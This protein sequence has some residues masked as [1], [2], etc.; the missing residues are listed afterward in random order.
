MAHEIIALIAHYGLLLVFINVLV[1][2]A[3]VPVPAVPTLVVAGALA[4]NG[5]LS[6]VAVL[7]VTIAACLLSDLAWYWAGRRFGAGVM[8]TL[9]R[10]SLS[11]DS[12]VRQSELRFDRWRG[13]ILLV[14]KFIPGLSTVAPPLVGAMGLRLPVFVL[15][16]VLGSLI[17]A[18]VAVALGFFFSMQIDV[19]L[20]RI[21]NAGTLAFEILMGLLALYIVGKWWQRRR[22]LMTL[23]MSRISVD[24]LND[25]MSN[26]KAIA[27]IDVRS[28]SS[29]LLDNRV[30]PGALMVDAQGIDRT[31]YDIPLDRELIVYCNCPNEVSAAK[32]AKRLMEQGYRRV[33]PLLGGLDAWD[34]AGYTIE[35]LPQETLAPSEEALHAAG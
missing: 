12:C 30:I 26:D 18:S 24:E 8:R 14:A 10:V 35:R 1:E 29:R 32:I 11:P 15:F 23:R 4:A 7:V 17:W 21:A 5:E 27:V 16:D 25:A 20:T 3:G 31:V 19:L 22:L 33:R 9:C 34:A 6:L 28:A 2:Q 13:Q